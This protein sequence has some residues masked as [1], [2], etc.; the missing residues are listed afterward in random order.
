[1]TV[2]A[3]LVH[4]CNFF[5]A[6]IDAEMNYWIYIW[7]RRMFEFTTIINLGAELLLLYQ[8]LGFKLSP[9]TS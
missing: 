8:G 5:P 6:K 4:V 1:M 9:H 3:K 2:K 7:K